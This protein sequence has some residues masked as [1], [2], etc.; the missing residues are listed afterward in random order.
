MPRK[1]VP[2]DPD[3]D[4]WRVVAE[5]CRAQ[6]T[7]FG[8]AINAGIQELR[9]ELYDFRGEANVRFEALEAAVRQNSA[10]IRQN[11]ADIRQNS[12]DIRQNSADIA[13]NSADIRDL[14][15]RVGKLEGLFERVTALEKDSR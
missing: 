1:K 12:A 2:S 6:L 13:G 7:V 5:D 15:T 11:S 10:D 9:R 4:I 14:S 8:D 3:L